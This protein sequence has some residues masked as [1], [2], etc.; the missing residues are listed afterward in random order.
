MKQKNIY[1]VESSCSGDGHFKKM[2]VIGCLAT[3]DIPQKDQTIFI[4]PDIEFVVKHIYSFLHINMR[5][6][7]V[8]YT[9]TDAKIKKDMEF[10]T[11]T[12]NDFIAAPKLSN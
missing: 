3:D 8:G 2:K 9:L 7:C 1:L 12:I 6:V 5:I 4:Q 11:E 10:M